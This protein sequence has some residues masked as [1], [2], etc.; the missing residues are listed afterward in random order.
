LQYYNQEVYPPANMRVV[1]VFVPL[2]ILGFQLTAA[3][4]SQWEQ[5]SLAALK[6]RIDEGMELHRVMGRELPDWMNQFVQDQGILD[7]DWT[8][9]N[10]EICEV[11]VDTLTR[12]KLEEIEQMIKNLTSLYDKIKLT[13]DLKGEQ[14][15][16]LEDILHQEKY[17]NTGL[18][19]YEA[20]D[21]TKPLA[22]YIQ[23]A[24]ATH[25]EERRTI[26]D[27][28]TYV[29]ETLKKWEDHPCNC[30]W[31]QWEEWS[32][33]S[34]TCEGGTR[35]RARSIA[36]S[37]RQGGTC[38]EPD[39]EDE[40]CNDVCCPVDCVITQWSDWSPCERECPVTEQDGQVSRHRGVEIDHECGGQTCE[41]MAG[42]VWEESKDCNIVAELLT[43]IGDLEKES[44][45]CQV[46]EGILQSII[47]QLLD[48]Q[49]DGDCEPD[50]LSCLCKDG[51]IGDRC[52]DVVE[53]GGD[54]ADEAVDDVEIDDGEIDD[55]G[56][57]ISDIVLKR[58]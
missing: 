4:P 39:L 31:A 9:T 18:K 22:D 51:F 8:L 14:L 11:D 57:E 5:D 52:Q 3:H 35:I 58:Q 20:E 30:F 2:A 48:C 33:C 49:N 38:D 55:G 43:E 15:S 10:E 21:C 34:V 24:N 44:T 6:Q 28:K 1:S 36:L 47:C 45:M 42:G 41:D 7:Q 40:P 32:R 19:K 26:E 50:T 46:S 16:T 37:I 29:D 23:N 54:E 25:E 13:W 12:P 53:D 27:Y 17:G 56:D